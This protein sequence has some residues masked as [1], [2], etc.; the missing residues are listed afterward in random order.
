MRNIGLKPLNITSVYLTTL[1]CLLFICVF[2][3]YERLLQQ[4]YTSLS[5]WRTTAGGGC[6]C[7][8]VLSLLL[9]SNSVCLQNADKS[10]VAYTYTASQTHIHTNTHSR[11]L[12]ISY[13]TLTTSCLIC[14]EPGTCAKDVYKELRKAFPMAVVLR[15]A[16]CSLIELSLSHCLIAKLCSLI[17]NITRQ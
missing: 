13:L 3:Q 2:C 11:V 17:V 1:L 16:H 12:T 8:C 7:V 10:Q 4:I 15:S 5:L 6:V 14:K 9:M